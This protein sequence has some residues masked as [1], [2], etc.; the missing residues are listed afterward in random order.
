MGKIKFKESETL[1]FKKSTS[2]LKEAIISIVAILNKHQSGELYFGI[3]DDGEVIGQQIGKDTERDISIAISIN[4]E[5]KIYPVVSTVKIKDKN[6][7]KVDFKGRKTIYYAFDRPYIRIGVENRKLSPDE[8]EELILR[9]NRGKLVWDND[10]CP[11]AKTSDVSTVKIKA[12]L[13]TAGLKYVSLHNAL[14]N[15]KLI[16]ENK[17][18]NAGIILFGKKPQDFFPNAKLRCAVFATT[19]TV[20]PIDMKDFE[21]DVFY[22]I[23]ST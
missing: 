10:I 13:K 18:V 3:R 2:E 15:L 11:K 8:Q 19:D 12:Y 6:C 22:L 5:P 14:V 4:I 23:K 9:K 7:I 20:T 1:E 16:S 17:I 21:G